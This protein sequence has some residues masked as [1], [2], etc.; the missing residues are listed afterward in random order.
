MQNGT[1]IYFGSGTEGRLPY[2]RGGSGKPKG[3]TELHK[4]LL[5]VVSIGFL[6]VSIG[7]FRSFNSTIQVAIALFFSFFLLFLVTSNGFSSARR[8]LSRETPASPA[9]QE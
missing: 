4:A 7:F 1:V 9:S 6:P 3:A 5:L 8:W 2:R